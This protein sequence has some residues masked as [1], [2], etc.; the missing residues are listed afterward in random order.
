VVQ[1][2]QIKVDTAAAVKAQEDFDAVT[3]RTFTAL[4]EQAKRVKALDESFLGSAASI[5]GYSTSQKAAAG[6]LK[7]VS[8]GLLVQSR[9]SGLVARGTR[10]LA[11]ESRAAA[12]DNGKLGQSA[13]ATTGIL[14]KLLAATGNSG[15]AKGIGLLGAGFRALVTSV[16]PA[17]IAIGLAASALV[18]FGVQAATAQS[19]SEKLLAS[20]R[21]QQSEYS[22]LAKAIDAAGASLGK[23][24][25]ARGALFPADAEGEGKRL[26]GLLESITEAQTNLSEQRR[27]QQGGDF[28]VTAAEVE[29]LGTALGKTSRFYRDLEDAQTGGAEARG[30]AITRLRDEIG[31]RVRDGALV[32]DGA[33]LQGE[34]KRAYDETRYAIE[35]N[36]RALASRAEFDTTTRIG[37][38][39]SEILAEVELQ[40]LGNKEREVELKLREATKG[41]LGPLTAEQAKLRAE[42]LAEAKAI[43]ARAIAEER[44][45]EAAKAAAATAKERATAVRQESEERARLA[46]SFDASLQ[47]LQRESS[48][49]T[50]DQQARD[51]LRLTMELENQAIAARIPLDDRVRRIIETTVSQNIAAKKSEDDRTVALQKAKQAA[52]DLADSEARRSEAVAALRDETA[53]LLAGTK[54]E[55]EAKTRLAQVNDLL[56]QTGAKPG[57]DAAKQIADEVQRNQ[58][59]REYRQT[60]DEIGRVGEQAFGNIGQGIVDT[61]AQGGTLRDMLRGIGQD[62]LRL[63]AQRGLVDN[64]AQLGGIVARGIGSFLGGGGAGGGVARSSPGP[65]ARFDPYNARGGGMPYGAGPTPYFAARG[66][67]VDQYQTILRGD[68]GVTVAEGGKSTPEAIMPLERDRYGRLGV[69][70]AGGGPSTINLHLPGV[71]TASDARQLRPTLRQMMGQLDRERKRGMR[72]GT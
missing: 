41:V 2:V 32:L 47:G 26:L 4:E 46:S 63:A 44:A 16:N 14:Q 33:R 53:I 68:R 22:N 31:L 1:G 55:I 51:K 35:E 67:V 9:N 42:T 61:V 70:S 5:S 30:Q 48:L 25:T 72:A 54:E 39:R 60:L 15:A 52:D 3:R 43:D 27:R 65:G 29:Q 66:V 21:D 8:D 7:V 12:V 20:A 45:S 18:T 23:I 17:G 64:L 71:R 49:L 69:V 38:V 28:L 11:N 34:L 57:S 59:A 56:R 40:R 6:S 50:L 62:L 10:D 36:N 19:A 24:G 13:N 58:R 37:S